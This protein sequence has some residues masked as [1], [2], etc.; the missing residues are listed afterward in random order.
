MIKI[1]PN[2]RTSISLKK[3]NLIPSNNITSQVQYTRKPNSSAAIKFEI[4]EK[5]QNLFVELSDIKEDLDIYLSS[6][7]DAS[8]IGDNEGVIVNFT[9]TSS[10]KFGTED[11][12]LF[13]Q[14]E[15][16]TYYLDIRSNSGA[17]SIQQSVLNSSGILTFNTKY[18][19]LV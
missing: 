11:E 1:K 12:L 5:S 9:Y 6:A 8:F 3:G 18:F 14:L 7:K 2:T 13:A 4:E 15:P 16:G 19:K 17:K 10:T